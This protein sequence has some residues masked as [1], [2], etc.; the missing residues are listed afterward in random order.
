MV[1]M[2][3]GV[4][5]SCLSFGLCGRCLRS[6]Q[7]HR[8]PAVAAVRTKLWFAA[9]IPFGDGHKKHKRHKREF[10]ALFAASLANSL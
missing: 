7:L 6:L 10:F 3:G 4:G 1:L 2:M 5:A 9:I 8:R